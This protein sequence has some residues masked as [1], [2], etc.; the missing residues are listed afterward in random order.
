MS[1][2]ESATRYP[3]TPNSLSTTT[4]LLGLFLIMVA[5]PNQGSNGDF[6]AGLKV[7][8]AEQNRITAVLTK[9]GWQRQPKDWKRRRW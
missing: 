3:L 9:L 4:L 8:K 5:P 6:A 2:I 1:R 7:G